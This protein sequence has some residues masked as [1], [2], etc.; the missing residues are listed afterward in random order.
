MNVSGVKPIAG[1]HKIQNINIVNS[2]TKVDEI[3]EAKEKPSVTSVNGGDASSQ[4]RDYLKQT[5]AAKD[6]AKQY[7]SRKKY[8]LKGKDSDL[9][10]LDV[11]KAISDIQK[12]TLMEQYKSFVGEE[13]KSAEDRSASIHRRDIENFTL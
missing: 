13:A 7:D 6:M 2:P 10:T 12:N 9:S 8:D 3:G 1:F 5:F 4:E 11:E